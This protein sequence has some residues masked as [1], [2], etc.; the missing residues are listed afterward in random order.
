MTGRIHLEKRF[1]SEQKYRL[2][3]SAAFSAAAWKFDSGVEALTLGNQRGFITILPF[4]GQ[5][6]WDA[7]FDGRNL[8]MKNMFRQPIPA[9]E[10]IETYGCYLFHSGMLRNGCPTPEDSHLL[11]GEMPCAPLSNAE[12]V[13]G[14]KNGREFL[15]LEGR[16]EYVMG[17]G[18]HYLARPSIELAPDSGVLE[19]T[20]SIKNLGGHDMEL[21]YMCHINPLFEK[22]AQLIQPMSYSSENVVTR[23]SIPDHVKPTAQWQDFLQ[24]VAKKPETMSVLD[25]PQNY[26]PEFVFFLKNMACDQSNLTHFLM[27][28]KDGSGCYCSYSL[29]EFDHTVRWILANPDQ[30]VAAFALP[31]TCEPEGYT[32]EK[33]KDNIK[34]IQPGETRSFTV[35]TGYL[36]AAECREKEAFIKSL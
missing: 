31:G 33:A 34:I 27:K 21:M 3:D 32:A 7:I 16:Y 19:V 25:T 36:S 13:F 6:I 29:K 30:S 14:E 28:L 1:F 15:R 20:M 26:H 24:E 17:F 11:H 2:F 35:H 5:M 9:K 10:I 22:G 23:T 12:L 18:S 8:A 4:M